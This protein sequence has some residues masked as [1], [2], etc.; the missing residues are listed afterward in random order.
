[1]KGS[2]SQ[3]GIF[4]LRRSVNVATARTMSVGHQANEFMSRSLPPLKS[5]NTLTHAI[6]QPN[7]SQLRIPEFSELPEVPR[8]S[9]C[10]DVYTPSI[11]VKR[12]IYTPSSLL[13]PQPLPSR[14]STVLRTLARS[15][16]PRQTAS[17]S[18]QTSRFPRSLP[19]SRAPESPRQPHRRRI[20]EDCR[21]PRHSTGS[22][23]FNRYLKLTFQ[24][25]INL[26]V[27][28]F[29]VITNATLTAGV[30]T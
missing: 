19:H 4:R 15:P 12:S 10:T 11:G 8:S 24:R 22:S 5:E 26:M 14:P 20:G 6:H 29:Q 27:S 3:F 17:N 18:R 23:F 25:K 1:M 21:A 7:F 2:T 16:N 13:A 28:N 30:S 9:V